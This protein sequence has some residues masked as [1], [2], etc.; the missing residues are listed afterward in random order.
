MPGTRRIPLMRFDD[1]ESSAFPGEY[2]NIFPIDPS[3]AQTPS[4]PPPLKRITARDLLDETNAIA[5][6]KK[7]ELESTKQK[8]TNR[9]Q[10]FAGGAGIGA[11]I[12]ALLN[13]GGGA[14]G[15][16]ANVA[17]VVTAVG[18]LAK[19]DAALNQKDE[20]EHKIALGHYYDAVIGAKRLNK[21]A[22][23]YDLQNRR[24]DAQAAKA[25]QKANAD[26]EIHSYVGED[27]KQH[28][29]MQKPDG[30]Y[31]DEVFGGV[32]DTKDALTAYQQNRIEQDKRGDQEKRGLKAQDEI[33]RVQTR[34]KGILES[35]AKVDKGEAVGEDDLSSLSE[36]DRAFMQQ[37]IGKDA[38]SLTPQQREQM[39]EV[40]TNAAKNE[41]RNLNFWQK[42]AGFEVTPGH[43][44]KPKQWQKKKW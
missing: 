14:R 18:E 15:S 3:T 31:S 24:L 39:K 35:I 38:K 1:E 4:A 29:I 5:A 21:V 23:Q 19:S 9:T 13:R 32:R 27:G 8:R 28:V 34:Y 7:A 36:V 20:A 43:L 33:Q 41:E 42:H 6:P 37:R 16:L 30:T 40:L 22:D 2:S 12:G 10:Q 11:V 44:S 25:A 26:K 17:P